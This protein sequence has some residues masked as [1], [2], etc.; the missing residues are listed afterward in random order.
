MNRV[1]FGTN[2]CYRESMPIPAI[3]DILRRLRALREEKDMRQGYVAMRLG[4]A[5]T[6]YVKKELGLIPITT[7]EWLRLA[8]VMGRDPGYFFSTGA[9]R[10]GEAY[11]CE[12][13]GDEE[14][15]LS[16]YR[17]LDRRERDVLISG[18]CLMFNWSRRKRVREQIERFCGRRP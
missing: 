14:R 13:E 9:P 11:A 1:A 2:F 4:I 15:L 5:R 16:L 8:V 6:T 18:V 3:R 7:D 10:R 12:D 17:A